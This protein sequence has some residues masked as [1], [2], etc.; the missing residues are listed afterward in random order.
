[1]KI[2]RQ[3]NAR[4]NDALKSQA[5]L[6]DAKNFGIDIHDPKSFIV[7]KNLTEAY[8]I[9]PNLS[10]MDLNLFHGIVSTPTLSPIEKEAILR[11]WGN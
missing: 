7:G 8:D 9:N 3:F 6:E 4:F 2:A 10:K 1:M 5:L 11:A